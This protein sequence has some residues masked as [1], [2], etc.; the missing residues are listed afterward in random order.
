MVRIWESHYLTRTSCVMFLDSEARHLKHRPFS[1]L[2]NKNTGVWYSPIMSVH[3][4]NVGISNV[5]ILQV[6]IFHS[7]SKVWLQNICQKMKFSCCYQSEILQAGATGRHS[8][9]AAVT[10]DTGSA[11]FSSTGIPKWRDHFKSRLWYVYG[12]QMQL[13]AYMLYKTV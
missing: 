5:Y 11:L 3:C 13:Y 1:G 6:G 10:A 12:L 7:M 9:A 2:V 8:A 4:V